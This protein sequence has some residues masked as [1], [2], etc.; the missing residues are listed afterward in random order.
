MRIQSCRKLNNSKW[1]PDPQVE[2]GKF[3]SFIEPQ[4]HDK[5]L[6]CFSRI[7]AIK[8]VQDD[9]LTTEIKQKYECETC[10]NDHC[11]LQ[12]SNNYNKNP[13]ISLDNTKCIIDIHLYLDTTTISQ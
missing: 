2:N 7:N 13:G 8:L 5:M 11:N 9:K 1:P 10:Q 3:L 4:A 12:N 6:G